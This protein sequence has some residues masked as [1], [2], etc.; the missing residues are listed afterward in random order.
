MLAPA[1]LRPGMLLLV[2]LMAHGSTANGVTPEQE[3]PD[4][5]TAEFPDLP[6]P[7]TSFGAARTPDAIYVY[8]GHTGSAHSYSSA[9]QSNQLL[10]LKLDQLEAG[11]QEIAEGPRLQGLAMVAHGNRVIR[12][13]GFTARNDRDQEQDLHSRSSVALYDP[14]SGAWSELPDLPEPRSS[15]DAAILGSRIYVVGGWQLDDPHDAQWHQTAWVLDLDAP[16]AAWEALPEPPL[17]RR[18]LAVVGHDEKLYVIGGMQRD[19]G[20]TTATAVYDP[21]SSRWSEG[22]S[23]PGPPMNG[24]GAAAA[25]VGGKL[26]VS[27]IEGDLLQLADDADSWRKIG[28]SRDAKFFH[29]LVPLDEHHLLS[30]G[31]ANME[32]GKFRQLEVIDLTRG[33]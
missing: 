13:G 31:G 23:L 24:F 8:G 3:P 27:T 1:D 21:A 10:R 12:L 30:I 7:L 25:S 19:G 28:Q 16:S 9:E 15:F 6:M 4:V 18:A 17:V 2:A 11:W 14:A 22:P 32:T 5:T 29:E 33:K 26:I 20:P